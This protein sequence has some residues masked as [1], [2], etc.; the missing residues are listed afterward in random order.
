MELISLKNPVFVAYVVAAT[1]MILKV[2]SMS[3]LTVVRMIQV[4]GGFRSPED[5]KKTRFNPNP[6][7]EQ[8][9]PNDRVERIRRIHM[10]DLENVPF[11]LVAGFLFVLTDPAL[12]LAQILMYT[13]VVSRL[14]HFAAYFSG[15]THDTRAMLW[16]PGALIIIFMAGWTLVRVVGV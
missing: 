10:N 6:T 12:L 5:I 16:T 11:F 9:A 13:Y 3:W 4:N 1:I 14:L 2:A 15:R 8:L 7:P